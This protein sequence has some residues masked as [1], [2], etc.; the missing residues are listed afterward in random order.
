MRKILACV[1]GSIYTE[2]VAACAAWASERTGASIKLL[3]AVSSSPHRENT[4]DLSGAIGLGAKGELLEHLAEL[5][6]SHGRLEQRKGK[7]IL[8]HA[9][10]LVRDSGVRH[11]ER[12]HRRG[13]LL[14]AIGELENQMDL[15][16]MGK[17][18]EHADVDSL[19]PGP[20]LERV[21]RA[22]HKPLLVSARIFQPIRRVLFAFDGGPS[23]HKALDYIARQ[24]LLKGLEC[25]VLRVGRV[26]DQAHASLIGTAHTLEQAGLSV[27]TAVRMG[28]AEE[29]MAAYVES[30]D[31][32]LVVMG[33]YGHS[34]IRSLI[35]G[36]T[37]TAM[38]RSCNVPI[39]LF[40]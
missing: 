29:V 33:A 8:E 18:G 11:I 38:I 24:P 37:T 17:R 12:L 32:D 25:H 40:R 3:Y 23:A 19:H 35:I 16:V 27:H 10:Q 20:N 14:E 6:E 26:S 2:T 36:S 7:L 9:E 31:I 21:A 5:D 13:S 39:L 28:N 34:R 4:P 15:I 30:K 1:D 22:I